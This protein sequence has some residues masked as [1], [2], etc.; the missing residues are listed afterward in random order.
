MRYIPFLLSL[1]LL[2]SCAPAE[3][4]TAVI[5]LSHLEPLSQ[6]A[7]T[8]VTPLRVAVAAI[9]SPKGTID[10][11]A[12]LLD[13]LEQELQRPVDLVQRRTY[14]EVNDLIAQGEI[15]LAFVCTSA[16]V[17]GVRDFDM[18]LLAA[19]QVNG[20][21]IYHSLLL[22]AAGSPARTMS[23]LQGKVFAFTDPISH[24]GRNYPTYLVQQLGH[25][26]DTFFART[27][28]TYSHDNAIYAVADGVADGAAVD[29]LIYEFARLRD[30]DLANRVRI[31]HRSPPFGIPPVV[32]GP[33]VRPQ[34]RADMQRVLMEMANN[35]QGQSALAAAGIDQF[36]LISDD[37]YDTVREVEMMVREK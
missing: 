36:V 32:V 17:T 22:V 25:T 23:D 13:Y 14:M 2:A 15:D 27:F 33:H 37:R 34:L 6:P 20:D 10:S 11:Y 26:P 24:S 28:F 29:S 8:E 3:P 18:Q 19:P 31:I 12:P 1:L 7:V 30:P 21:T 4:A 5:D 35:P 16:Y 9:I